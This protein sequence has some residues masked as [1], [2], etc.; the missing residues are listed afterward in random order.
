[1]CYPLTGI[2]FLKIHLNYR[3][4]VSCNICP[5]DR[6]M[7]AVTDLLPVYSLSEHEQAAKKSGHQKCVL[8]S[9]L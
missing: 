3:F 9:L 7:L 8:V 1:M 5:Q 2:K 6:K 4:H